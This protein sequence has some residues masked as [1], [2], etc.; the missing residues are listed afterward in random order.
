MSST[1][2]HRA[3]FVSLLGAPNAGKSTLFNVLVG[4]P[5]AI[6]TPKVQTTRHRTI[7]VYTDDNIQV[8][9]SDTPG[10]IRPA[11]RLQ[12]AM[13]QSVHQARRDADLLIWVHDAAHSV[14]PQHGVLQSSDSSVAILVLLNK[15]D[16][17][18]PV[19]LDES[20]QAWREAYPRATVLAASAKH[21]ETVE[22]LRSHIHNALPAHPPYYASDALTDRPERFFAAEILREKIFL[23]YRKE[24]PYCT[25]VGIDSFEQHGDLI[26][27]AATIRV[28]RQSQRRI[29]IGNGGSK[30]KQIGTAARKDLAAFFEKRIFLTQYVRVVSGWRNDKK[31]L[32][33]FG[34][35]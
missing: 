32:E 16:L 31:R 30:L 2:P 10:V 26:R 15:A 19:A 13:M 11:Y 6:A 18:D 17:V 29:L 12:E 34:Y 33:Q 20:V 21:P 8:V 1:T 25:E 4:K 22:M 27:I 5:L 24:V 35:L 14:H 3:G 28:E 7:G 9:Y 23:F